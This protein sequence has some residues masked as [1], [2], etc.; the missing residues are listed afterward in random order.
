V[1]AA[2][3]PPRAVAFA[4]LRRTFEE[5]AYAD[6]ALHAEAAGLDARDRALA[7]RMAFGTIQHRATLDHVAETLAKRPLSKL[8]APV[9]A[10]LRL[11]LFQLLHLDAVPA[12]AAVHE[13]VELVKAH[14]HGAGLVN[15]VLRRATREAAGLVAKL[16]D[17]TPEAAALRHSHP[18]WLARMWW[19]E[20]GADDA[21]ALMRAN[22]EPSELALRAN[23][24]VIGRDELAARLPVPTRPAPALPEGLVAEQ[25]FD[26]HGSDLWREGA[27]TPHSRAS[28]LVA[29][30]V[31]PQR[32]DRVLDLCAAPGMKGTHLAALMGGEGEVVAVERHEGR[33]AAMRRTAERL[34]APNVDVRVGDARHPPVDG[35]FDRVLVDPPCSGLGTLASRPDLRWRITADAVG[36]LAAR[37]DEILEAAGAAV[38]P[39]G[40]LVYSTCT[41]ARA[42]N[43]DMVT[44]FLARNPGFALD[45]GALAVSDFAAWQHPHMPGC[46]LTLPHRHATDGFFVA[47]MRRNPDAAPGR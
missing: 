8:D 10:A 6:R 42:E 23:T 47:R 40:V 18:E 43:E 37:Q 27:F 3:S 16:D 4:V 5:D 41:L 31:D 17:A 13:S 28:M 46:L 36:E 22:N 33:A 11:G 44:G 29:R 39:G 1:S 2:V 14:G 38:R 19:D 15:A 35:V 24:L 7:T 45:D 32:G 21:R 9:V 25:P 26:A 20:L 34:C 30:V 12:H